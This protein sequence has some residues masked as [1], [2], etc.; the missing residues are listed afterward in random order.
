MMIFFLFTPL[1]AGFSEL[2]E[3]GLYQ[4]KSPS[5]SRIRA[6]GKIISPVRKTK[7]KNNIEKG[8]KKI[9]EEDKKIMDLLARQEK[10]LIVRRSEDKIMA[11]T[12]VRGL[13][14][15]SIVAMSI[16][17]SQFVV[18]IDSDIEGIHGGEVR[19]QGHSFDRRVLASCDLLVVDDKEFKI[20]IDIW[21]ID[22][23]EGITADYFYSGE[24]K[25]FI[26]SSFASFLEGV[27]DA[28][29]DRISTPFGETNRNNAKNKI[30]GGLMGVASNVRAK[31]NQAGEQKITIAFINSGRK[32]LLFFNKTLNLSQEGK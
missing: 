12:R 22:G 6:K 15:N 26:T 30:M 9:M 28:S 10:G 31:I 14:L 18:R 21:G 24:E 25:A 5:S 27:L 13:L 3:G 23:A 1:F 17:P 11:L 8:L 7:R 2:P 20:D 16:K 19:C 32:V 29:K 4:H